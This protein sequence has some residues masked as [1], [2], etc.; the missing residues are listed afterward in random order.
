MKI[1]NLEISAL[2]YGGA[3]VGRLSD[4]R[5]CFVSGALPGEN[6]RIRIAEEK[7]RF[8]RGEIID[9]IKASKERRNPEC[10]LF[11][12]CPGCVYMHCSYAMEIAWKSRQLRD[13]AVRNK[14]AD[15]SV[16]QKAFA[17]P[18]E[19]YYRN[20]IT[21]HQ[22]EKGEYGYYGADNKTLIPVKKCLLADS[23]INALFA[24]AVGNTALFRATER[25]GALQVSGKNPGVLHEIIPGAGEFSVAGNGFF[26]T[27][28]PVASELVQMVKQIFAERDSE[29]TLLELYCGTG[30]FS[31]ALAETF[32]ELHCCGIEINADLAALGH[33][34][35]QIFF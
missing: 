17:S 34:H 2:A 1:E 8:C 33:H 32:P 7:K 19:L 5:V 28:I 23:R 27:N 22:S 18:V 16:I 12:K 35:A 9:V 14:I 15:E 24:G 13:F 25:D 26:Q 31:I 10:P 3:G 21:L 30:V 4:G 29:G 6:V 11:G 20:K